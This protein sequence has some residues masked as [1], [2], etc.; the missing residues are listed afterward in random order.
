M[1]PVWKANLDAH[2]GAWLSSDI[3]PQYNTYYI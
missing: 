3:E 2:S 1:N